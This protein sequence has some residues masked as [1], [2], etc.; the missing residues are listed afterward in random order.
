MTGGIEGEE[1]SGWGG[2]GL[3]AAKHTGGCR[4]H[5][6]NHAS[7]WG[8]HGRAG[9]NETENETRCRRRAGGGSDTSSGS[10]QMFL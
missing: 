6:A 4:S 2:D 1:A 7:C 3:T 10:D 5:T 9:G 8:K